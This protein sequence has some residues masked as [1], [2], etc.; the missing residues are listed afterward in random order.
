MAPLRPRKPPTCSLVLLSVVGNLT[1]SGSIHMARLH[2]STMLLLDVARMCLETR[3]P[4]PSCTPA[5]ASPGVVIGLAVLTK[6]RVQFT[7]LNQGARE[8]EQKEQQGRRV[9]AIREKE[10]FAFS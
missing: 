6:E 5:L 9:I 4:C 1:W 7:V 3:T 2:V 10:N 8:L